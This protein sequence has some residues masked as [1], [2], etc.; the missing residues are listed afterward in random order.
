MSADSICAGVGEGEGES[1]GGR[2]VATAEGGRSMSMAESSGM[3]PY[4]IVAIVYSPVNEYHHCYSLV[5][6]IL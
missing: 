6:N 2:G 1:D 5:H 4:Q 3:M